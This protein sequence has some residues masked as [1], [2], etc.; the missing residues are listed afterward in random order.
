MLHGND[1]NANNKKPEPDHQNLVV[2][3]YDSSPKFKDCV[4]SPTEKVNDVR[5]MAM[6][7]DNK[8]RKSVHW[9]EDLVM[10]SETHFPPREM[11]SSSSSLVGAKSNPYVANAP[12][13]SDSASVIFKS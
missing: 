10:E 4:E 5:S 11:S 8:I 6:D 2:S 13:P 7:P 9:S 12:A 3:G 1:E